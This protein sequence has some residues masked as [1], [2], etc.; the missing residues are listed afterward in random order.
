ME[1][2]DDKYY[3]IFCPLTHVSAS[4]AESEGYGVDISTKAG[5]C[6]PWALAW[7]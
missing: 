5:Q 3:P 1:L 7:A 6:V 2:S 4:L